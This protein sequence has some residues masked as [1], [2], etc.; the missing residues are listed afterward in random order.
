V[1]LWI[2]AF[3]GFES[4]LVNSGEVK[5]PRRNLPFAL[6]IA[7]LCI[8]TIYILILMVSIGTL[9]GLAT[10]DKPLAAA[11]GLFMGKW[12]ALLIGVGAVVSITG[13]LNAIMLVGSRLPFAFSVQGQFPAVFQQIHAKYATPVLSLW[14]FA[15]VTLAVSLSQSFIAAA[16]LSAITRV[17]IYGIICIALLRLRKKDSGA[18]TYLKL[19]YGK[20]LAW[21]ALPIVG[22]LLSSS[23]QQEI[24]SIAIALGVGLLIYGLVVWRRKGK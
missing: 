21:I 6:L 22:W 4:V 17:M 5:E 19:R 15:A 10:S 24:I 18:E 11:A 7:T 12:G 23:K 2:F 9:P 13:T 3:G 1:L 20:A 8:A 14:V 16:T